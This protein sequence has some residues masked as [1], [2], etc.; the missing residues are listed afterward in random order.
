MAERM[1]PEECLND[2]EKT[3]EKT[4]NSTV[5]NEYFEKYLKMVEEL[6]EIY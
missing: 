3:F 5:N 6:S 2:M 4:N 1:L